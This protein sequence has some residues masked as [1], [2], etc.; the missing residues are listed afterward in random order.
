MLIPASGDRFLEKSFYMLGI[1]EFYGK[2]LP[3]LSILF[4]LRVKIS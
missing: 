2:I 1:E 4:A 3:W